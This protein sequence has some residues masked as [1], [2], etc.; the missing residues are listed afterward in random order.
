MLKELKEFVLRGNVIDMA[1]GIIIGASFGT[2]VSSLVNDI[3]MP[4]IGLLL[5]GI[6]FSNLFI[7]LNP[8]AGI[9]PFTSLEE[10]QRAGAVTINYGVFIN[11]IVAFAIVSLALF[12]LIRVINKLS[13]SSKEEV[14]ESNTK[15]CPYCFSEIPLKAQRCP[16]CTSDVN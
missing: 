5:G 9:A 1:V 6:D 7:L 2:I 15:E 13:K 10:A 8:G 14:K 16:Y 4:P 11:N 3:I 12:I